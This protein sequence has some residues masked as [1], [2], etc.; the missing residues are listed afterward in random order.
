MMTADNC[1]TLSGRLS[2]RRCPTYATRT[3]VFNSEAL[4]SYFQLINVI[5]G[6]RVEAVGQWG[7]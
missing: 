4:I 5:S 2:G 7:G 3:L 6:S 1:V